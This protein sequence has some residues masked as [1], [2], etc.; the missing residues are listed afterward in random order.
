M[1]LHRRDR[2]KCLH[3]VNKE[4]QGDFFLFFLF[5]EQDAGCTLWQRTVIV[6]RMA[7]SRGDEK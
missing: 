3:A 4:S 2:G 5:S 1:K 7:W 6:T